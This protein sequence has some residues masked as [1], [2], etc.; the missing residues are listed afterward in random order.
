MTFAPDP[1]PRRH[2]EPPFRVA[3]LHGGPGAGGEVAPVARELARRRGVLEP[4]QT[5]TTLDGQV[6]ELSRQLEGH[7][8]PPV[9]LIGYSFGAWLGALV[10]A[11]RPELV[12]KLV[13]VSSGPFEESGSARSA[14]RRMPSTRSP[15]THARPT[16]SPATGPSS[17][18]SGPPP[19][20]S[21]GPG[22]S[23]T[24]AATRPGSNAT[25]APSAFF[26]ALEAILAE[27]G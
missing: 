8:A 27:D 15:G 7:A 25:P 11:V 14:R 5:A 17:R 10:A 2:G 13:L 3:V 6:G 20:S 19:P 24:A 18:A 26:A 21:A 4:L 22:A 16:P 1:N 9:V 23:S 12:R